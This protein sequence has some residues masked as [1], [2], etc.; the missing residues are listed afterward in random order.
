MDKYRHV[1]LDRSPQVITLKWFLCNIKMGSCHA[2]LIVLQAIPVF[3]VV[4]RT[5]SQ[6]KQKKK[7]D[8]Q[9]WSDCEESYYTQSLNYPNAVYCIS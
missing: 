7:S 8:I 6:I 1:N 2:K 9:Q 3:C 5:Q 4:S